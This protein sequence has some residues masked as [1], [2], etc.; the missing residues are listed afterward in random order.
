VWL[1]FLYCACDEQTLKHAKSKHCVFQ[2]CVVLNNTYVY[3]CNGCMIC[4]ICRQ[5]QITGY[6]TC[7][8]TDV[9][10]TCVR[11]QAVSELIHDTHSDTGVAWFMQGNRDVSESWRTVIWTCFGSG[12]IN[13]AESAFSFS[14]WEGICC[15]ATTHCLRLHHEIYVLLI[16]CSLHLVQK[17]NEKTEEVTKVRLSTRNY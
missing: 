17:F 5:S 4:L 14:E 2:L 15:G 13:Q 7:R 10:D 6:V 1:P 8:Q 9:Q 11:H 3:V 16:V 12:Y